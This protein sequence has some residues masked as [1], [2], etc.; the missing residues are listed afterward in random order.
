MTTPYGAWPSPLSA[1]DVAAGGIDL[2]HL[3][4]DGSTAYWLERRPSED[5]RGVVLA[6]SGDPTGETDRA[7]DASAPGTPVTPGDHDVRT[8]VHEYGGG[9]FAVDGAD[10]YYARFEDQRL[11]HVDL[12]AEDPPATA[13][14][15]TP[16]P[17]TGRGLRYADLEPRD[18]RVYAVRERHEG[19][20]T[21][22]EPANELVVVR[23]DGGDDHGPVTVVAEGHDFYSFPRLSPD[24][25]RLA[26]TTWDHPR[27][28]WDGTELHVADVRPDGTLADART[29][30][31][32][33]EE[34]VFQPSW[35]PD[36]DLYAVSDRTG[37]WNLYRVPDRDAGATDDDPRP[38]PD[39]L[40][41]AEAEFGTP[42]WVFG[43]STY[44]HLDDGRI[45]AVHGRG[46][47]WAL[48]VL[49]PETG[50]LSDVATGYGAY[51]HTRLRADG[52][53]LLT[54]AAGPADPE[55]VVRMR[56][57][58]A[59]GDAPAVRKRVLRRSVEVD[60][61]ERYVSQP[62]SV[63]VET[64]DGEQTHATYYPPHNP[65]VAAPE[66]APP[67]LTTVHGGPTSQSL[68]TLDLEVQFFTTRGVGVVDVNYRGSTGYGRAYRDRLR[69][70][71][72]VVDTAD[73][74]AAAEHLAATGRADPDRLAIRG[75]SAGG[76]A[77]LSALARHD[78]FDAGVSYYGVADLRTLAAHT[79]K[80]ESRYLDSLVGP[81]PEA[82]DRYEERSPVTHADGIA[83]PL[84][85]LQGSEDSVVP[86]EQAEAMVDALA[87]SGVPHAHVEFEGERHGFRREDSR[88]RALETEFGFLGDVFGF[89]PAEDLASVA[90]V[91]N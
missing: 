38:D 62:E 70:E 89:D 10:L 58:D 55:S 54:V 11:Y 59:E 31:G 75:G 20:G 82:G 78:A 13:E 41:P 36:G 14:P 51:P 32:G 45:A 68:P 5:G 27:M 30:M 66:G 29:V 88:R 74:V 15:V 71:W 76:Y 35:G 69:G 21:A 8:L 91:E 33:P 7:D 60:L 61:P 19:P 63:T 85:L 18:G 43:L 16:A 40:H 52:D 1:A 25:D 77:V 4:L 80:F 23:T 64:P 87:E 56:V 3:A 26:W 44:A 12:A 72:G 34:S 50:A 90:V 39:P 81:L 42:Q 65:D 6:D 57:E 84:L 83:A 73:C 2:G 48:G 53:D 28:P 79:H 46:E 86:P 47:D 67:L 9:D 17:E 24:G 22:D 37:W 49:D